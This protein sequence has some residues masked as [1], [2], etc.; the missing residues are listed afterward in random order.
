L[1]QT[2][3]KKEKT[4]SPSSTDQSVG[5]PTKETKKHVNWE[6]PRNRFR[7]QRL[8][9]AEWWQQRKHAPQLVKSNDKTTKN[10]HKF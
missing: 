8:W 4:T 10:R 1:L 5:E 3:M 6:M 2:K 9:Y 7:G